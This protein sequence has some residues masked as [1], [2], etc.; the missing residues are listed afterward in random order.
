MLLRGKMTPDARIRRWDRP[1]RRDAVRYEGGRE[2]ET[3]HV[4][5]HAEA[6]IAE[7][8]DRGH[9]GE[10]ELPEKHELG[11]PTTKGPRPADL[12]D[13]PEHDERQKDHIADVRQCRDLLQ[14]LLVRGRPR[15]GG[16]THVIDISHDGANMPEPI[17]GDAAHSLGVEE[18]LVPDL[19]IG[20]GH[21]LAT[22]ELRGDRCLEL[23]RER[24]W[25]ARRYAA[26]VA[27]TEIEGE[28][29]VF[30]DAHDAPDDQSL[31]R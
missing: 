25:G 2:R 5:R 31:V 24:R 9:E 30:A 19:M 11:P 26:Y 27:M 16:E 21:V 12:A 4:E 14:A 18:L 6:G 7:V 28:A 3:E 20:K 13:R 17:G 10:G 23:V 1:W 8:H 22:V 29:T 15:D